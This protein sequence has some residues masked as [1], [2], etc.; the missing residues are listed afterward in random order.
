MDKV[1]KD[2]VITV[3]ELK[4]MADET[5]FVEGMQLDRG[6]ISS[7]FITNADH[8][9]AVIADTYVKI[10]EKKISAA[11]DVVEIGKRTGL[12]RSWKETGGQSPFAGT[13]VPL[14]VVTQQ[15]EQ[16]RSGGQA[17]LPVLSSQ[18]GMSGL[19]IRTV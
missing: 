9:E 7:Y 17:F 18:T 10:N 4:S 12:A 5:E 3:E 19:L 2:G 15:V 11:E 14:G 16:S 6:Y 1:G 8:M 13:N